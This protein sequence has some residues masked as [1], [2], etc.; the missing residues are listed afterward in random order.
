[1]LLL[2]LFGNTPMAI[3]NDSKWLNHRSHSI[4]TLSLLASRTFKSGLPLFRCIMS[5]VENIFC[6]CIATSL[7]WSDKMAGGFEKGDT[8]QLKSGGPKMTVEKIENWNGEMSAWCQWFDG[9]KPMAN[10]FPLTSLK[11]D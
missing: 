9:N 11:K 4:L 7:K 10:R 3:P 8:V 5:P 2:K 1:M 6:S